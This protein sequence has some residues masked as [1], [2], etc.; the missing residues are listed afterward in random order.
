MFWGGD[1]TQD[2]AVSS[3]RPEIPLPLLP[4]GGFHGDPHV[5][6]GCPRR[7]AERVT[8]WAL[9]LAGRG[10]SKAESAG[11]RSRFR[12]GL[13]K[14]ETP[15]WRRNGDA[16]PSRMVQETPATRPTRP[17]GFGHPGSSPP[18]F[19]ERPGSGTWRA[20][21]AAARVGLA[22]RRL[23]ERRAAESGGRTQRAA[24]RESG[25]RGQASMHGHRRGPR[26]RAR[27]RERGSPSSIPGGGA[28]TGRVLLAVQW[29]K[30][31]S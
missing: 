20:R 1:S 6:G 7:A 8:G 9:D 16:R 14:E 5:P 28:S 25:R 19:H 2:V 18:P 15:G 26:A 23:G 3:G 31:K 10:L 27:R 12:S 24:G 13:G 22:M 30:P 4:Q 11:W 21:A 29:G 17:A